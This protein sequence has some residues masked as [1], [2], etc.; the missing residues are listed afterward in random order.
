DIGAN[1]GLKPDPLVAELPKA[2]TRLVQM[3]SEIAQ[4]RNLMET[5][6]GIAPFVEIAAAAVASGRR[7]D[8]AAADV[9]LAQAQERY[10]TIVKG[11]SEALER[12]RG[13][14]AALAEQRGH[15]A[16]TELRTR[17]AAEHYLSAA[18]GTPE[19][20]KDVAGRRFAM[21]GSALVVHGTSFFA[22]DDLLEAIRLFQKEALPRLGEASP[23]TDE[24][25]KTIAA[26][27]ALVLAELGDA[28]TRL[29]GRLP[30]I[31]GARMMVD[32]RATYGRALK[33]FEIGDFPGLAMDILDRRS[34]R[35]LE[36]GR[37][38]VKDRGRGHFGEAV[39]TMRL[40]LS[41][42]KGK[43]AFESELPRTVNNLANALKEAS[44]RT[45][46]E[47]GDRQIDEAIG[48]FETAAD[49]LAKQRSEQNVLIARANLAH[50]L[51][52]RA[53]RKPGLAGSGDIARAKALLA[54]LDTDL[55]QGRNPRLWAIVKRYEAELHRLIGERTTD[56]DQS[57]ASL[58]ASFE[59]FQ[60]ILP[61]TSR[62][63]APNDW[64]MLCADM[65]H[66]LV[67]A[68]PLVD[69]ASRARSADNAVKLFG[70]ARP[71]LV[72]GGF[73]QD[74]ERLDAALEKARP[75]VPAAPAAPAKGR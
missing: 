63:T 35:D 52:L 61:V 69:A 24:Q 40:I 41:I 29:G 13:K 50:A 70:V 31:E 60:K 44:R 3:R 21:A 57:F 22:N 66:T 10:D 5:E 19:A 58:K 37:R 72:A 30:G 7:P 34:Q 39:K 46:G 75:A 47:E 32:A 9:A 33:S 36:F 25:R 38:I 54:A 8:L 2:Y 71:Y 67:A 55:D 18:K 59:L 26:T 74:L 62:E 53:E 27:I 56:R 6:P 15:I 28:Q 45:E 17:E 43:P 11:R 1:S 4:F 68:L 48:L 20:E 14:R 73:G 51:A 23:A 49:L 16:E 64:A 12:A 42:Q 65:G